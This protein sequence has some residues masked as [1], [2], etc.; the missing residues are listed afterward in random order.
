MGFLENK[1]TVLWLL[2][3]LTVKTITAALKLMWERVRKRGFVTAFGA[4]ND[5][6]T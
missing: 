6:A 2:E 3:S 4:V 1:I 5:L